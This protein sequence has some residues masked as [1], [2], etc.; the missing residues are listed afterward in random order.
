MRTARPFDNDGLVL[1]IG[2]KALN[3][4]TNRVGD[5]FTPEVSGIFCYASENKMFGVGLRPA[6]R[7]ATAALRARRS[8]T[9]TSSPWNTDLAANRSITPLFVDTN[10]TPYFAG[11][12]QV[13]ATIENAPAQG[14]LYGIPND[15]RY[16]FSDSSAS[17][18]TPAHACSS[19]R[20]MVSTL[21]ADYTFAQSEIVE[22]RGEQTIWL[23]RNGFDHIVFDTNEAVATPVL[24]HEFTGAA[25]DFGYEQQHREQK[26]DLS[27]VGFNVDWE[28]SDRLQRSASTSTTPRRAACRTIR[29]TGGGETAFSLAGKVPSTCLESYGPNPA[30]PAASIPCRNASNFWTQTFQFNNGL[31]VASRTLFPDAVRRVCRTPAATTNYAFRRASLGS[32]VLRI[33]YNDQTTDIKQARLDG[34]FEISD[35]DTLGFGFETRAMDSRQRGSTGYMAL[36]RLGR[37][38]QRRR[39]RHGG[40]AD[41]LQPHRCVRRLQ[42]GGRAHRWLERQ[43]ERAGP[44]GARHGLYQRLDRSSAPDGQLRYNPGS[45]STA[46]CRRHAARCMRR[47][48]SSSSSAACRATS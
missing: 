23:Q 28:A 1:N 18:S 42:P 41:A 14:Q 5:D 43:C 11:D 32:Q 26:N 44:M 7:N 9:G 31:P 34:K 6:T 21:T 8:T 48:A 25:K 35:D 15:I 22:D 17:A 13:A 27:S 4:T 29:I 19:R 33:A 10:D 40:A 47:S 46:P 12:D 39:A 3:D 45:T 20:S 36:R 24:L 38:R 37:E 2:A 16:V 30:D